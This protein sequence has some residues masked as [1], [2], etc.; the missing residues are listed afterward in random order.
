MDAF[1]KLAVD[2]KF[3]EMEALVAPES[4]DDYYAGD[5]PDILDYRVEGVQWLEGGKKANVTMVSKVHTRH[6]KTGDEINEVP[7]ASHWELVKG[8]WYWYL[9]HVNRRVTAFGQMK[10]DP[11][12]A[13]QSHLN[14]KELIRKGPDMAELMNGVRAGA[15]T[16]EL[17]QEAGASASVVLTNKLPGTVDLVLAPPIGVGFTSTL[18]AETLKSGEQATLTLHSI[19]GIKR[20]ASVGIQVRPTGQSLVIQVNYRK[21]K[22]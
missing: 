22:P 7:Y 15:T 6:I 17:D 11:E 20:D 3:R 18:S 13:A 16:V 4:R 5:K 19:P 14:L 1:Y 10:V 2:H 12:K 8:T 9:P 21:P